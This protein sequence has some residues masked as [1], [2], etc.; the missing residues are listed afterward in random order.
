MKTL[1]A[2]QESWGVFSRVAGYV[3]AVVVLFCFFSAVATNLALSGEKRPAGG[4]QEQET[5]GVAQ[6]TFDD[7]EDDEF[8]AA[9]RMPIWIAPATK[10]NDAPPVHAKAKSRT[11]EVRK[12]EPRLKA[13]VVRQPTMPDEASSS[14]G[15]AGAPRGSDRDEQ[16]DNI[17]TGSLAARRSL[18]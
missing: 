3:G 4:A 15:Y 5:V 12:F 16:F 10:Y 7:I 1:S 18:Y 6:R 14:Y 2:E 9:N 17:P 8:S 13:R 11:I